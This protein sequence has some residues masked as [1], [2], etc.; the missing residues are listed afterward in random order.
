MNLMTDPSQV[1]RLAEELEEENWDTFICPIVFN[2]VEA[3]K[4]ELGWPDVEEL[5]E[6]DW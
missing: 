2:V 3:M 6:F 5:D 1:A 4:G